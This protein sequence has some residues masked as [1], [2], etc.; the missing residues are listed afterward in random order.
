M[1]KEKEKSVTIR[2]PEDKRRERDGNRR[3]KRDTAGSSPGTR[4]RHVSPG[5]SEALPYL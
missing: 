1:R 5:I 4:R 3:E 2:T